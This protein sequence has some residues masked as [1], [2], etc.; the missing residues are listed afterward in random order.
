MRLTSLLL[1]AAAVAI[2]AA[3]AEAARSKRVKSAA[4]QQATRGEAG[5]VVRRARTRITV[6]RR[7]YLD[8]GTEVYPGSM[9]YT[10]YVFSPNFGSPAHFHLGPGRRDGEPTPGT[11]SLWNPSYHVP[12]WGY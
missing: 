11:S 1:A 5:V 6:T 7:S 8:A 2:V 10:D 3:P 4:V 9:H 12:N